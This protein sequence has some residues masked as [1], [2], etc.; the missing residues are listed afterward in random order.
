MDN[1]QL[2]EELLAV[3][4]KSRTL[5]N[6]PHQKHTAF[7]R[8]YTHADAV[9]QQGRRYAVMQNLTKARKHFESAAN[10]APYYWAVLGRMYE[11]GRILGCDINRAIECYEIGSNRGV[12]IATFRLANLLMSMKGLGDTVHEQEEQDEQHKQDE[13]VDR[14]MEL[15]YQVA[16]C[17]NDDPNYVLAGLAQYRL[18]VIYEK[19]LLGDIDLARAYMWFS[20]AAQNR[21]LHASQE[22][23]RVRLRLS[24]SD[25]A[26]A[27]FWI[28][29]A[30]EYGIGTPIDKD[31]AC[32]WYAQSAEHGDAG[33]MH[34]LARNKYTRKQD[35][36]HVDGE[37]KDLL[38][39]AAESPDSFDHLRIG[40]TL[41]RGDLGIIDIPAAIVCFKKAANV[42]YSSAFYQLGVLY[43]EGKYVD[44][45]LVKAFVYYEQACTRGVIKACEARDE[46]HKVL[47]PEQR[48][49]IRQSLAQLNP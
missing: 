15:L 31:A 32:M 35:V 23:E 26:T 10:E 5:Q 17:K 27:D 40:E 38:L 39:L 22:L 2:N 30:L 29:H 44:K 47:T 34:W 25:E 18:A 19:G 33:A 21:V 41:L 43:D 42:G 16:T 8:L 4:D 13:R 9:F 1:P 36:T 6:V 11:K 45:D 12:T 46:L 7:M 3:S 49:L 28:G 37:V 48:K 14:A 20:I 24:P